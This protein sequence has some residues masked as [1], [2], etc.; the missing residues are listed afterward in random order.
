MLQL[1]STVLVCRVIVFLALWLYVI[2]DNKFGNFEWT[3]QKSAGRGGG[4][5]VVPTKNDFIGYRQSDISKAFNTNIDAYLSEYS[6]IGIVYT[7]ASW[8]IV[9]TR[10]SN[11][12]LILVGLP[13]AL[14][15][16]A[17]LHPLEGILLFFRQPA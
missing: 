16:A 14:Q 11:S 13:C 15:M 10:T 2:N 4:V 9:V 17:S 8:G 5:E 12:V 7:S 3:G 1:L 6:S